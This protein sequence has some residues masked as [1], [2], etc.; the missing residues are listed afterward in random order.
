M[1][2]ALVALSL[3][4]CALDAAPATP[5][6]TRPAVAPA[7]D[8]PLTDADCERCH[9]YD[10]RTWRSSAHRTAFVDEVFQ[11]EW[12]PLAQPECVRCHAPLADPDA[13]AGEAAELGVSCL[14]CHAAPGGSVRS[15]HAAP[16]APHPITVDPTLATAEACA[17]CHDFPFARV[18]PTRH[19][20]SAP[21]QRT[22]TEW[23]E[24]EERGA[25]QRCHFRDGER[26]SHGSPGA[27]SPALLADALDV[28]AR[29]E[30]SPGGTSV[31]L[32]LRS[33]AGHAVPTGDM[34][35]R[36]VVEAWPVGRPARAQR[37][38]LMR[39]FE[40]VDGI[41][42]EIGDDRVPPRGERTVHL[43]LPRAGRVAWRITWQ[44]LDPALARA[45]WIPDEVAAA[46]VAEGELDAE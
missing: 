6:P 43:A 19:D 10:A 34:Y 9:A 35:R 11:A 25:C 5:A 17:G 33:R 4:G 15:V 32:V 18:A 16:D 13:P 14:V 28:E 24:V 7:P 3:L 12:A 42:R 22:L 40:R 38:T 44:A 30:R 31:T 23:H 39:R 36:L 29:A 1:R 27:R 46:V 21:L 8:A 45:R 20:L 2:A 41:E 26:V 37:V